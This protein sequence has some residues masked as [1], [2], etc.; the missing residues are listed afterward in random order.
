V[1]LK[2]SQPVREIALNTPTNIIC[3]FMIVH[4]RVSE[5]VCS[6]VSTRG[7]HDTSDSK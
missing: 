2:L 3:V 5:G 6:R 7:C 4:L 1:T